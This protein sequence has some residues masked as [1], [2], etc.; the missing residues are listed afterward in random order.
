MARQRW[1]SGEPLA[2]QALS[3]AMLCGAS[4]FLFLSSFPSQR[5]G[6]DEGWWISDKRPRI[7]HRQ[8][9]LRFYVFLIGVGDTRAYDEGENHSS[10]ILEN[11]QVV[12]HCLVDGLAGLGFAQ[13]L[14]TKTVF[15]FSFSSYLSVFAFTH[16]FFPDT[17]MSS[18]GDTP[19]T[20]S[21]HFS[22][23]Y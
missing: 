4:T 13:A 2:L 7:W 11:S 23:K 22:F 15:S 3:A 5:S 9:C 12:H 10:N 18:S 14:L 16:S 6:N 21:L 20:S 1:L 19:T 17:V 8:V